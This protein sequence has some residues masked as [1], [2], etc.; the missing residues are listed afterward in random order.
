MSYFDK[1]KR[2][3]LLPAIAALN[4]LI[5]S[6]T[7]PYEAGS[8]NDPNCHPVI[9]ALVID[10]YNSSMDNEGKEELR[11]S[12]DFKTKIIQGSIDEDTPPRYLNHFMDWQ[13]GKGIW[14]FSS[15]LEWAISS[16]VQSGA[17]LP[18]E[19]VSAEFR[20]DYEKLLQQCNC[21]GKYPLGDKSWGEALGYL[22][23]QIYSTALG[24]VLHLAEDMT[25]PAHTRGDVHVL[26]ALGVEIGETEIKFSRIGDL[27]EYY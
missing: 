8:K 6:S 18:V 16:E 26:R 5:P 23:N 21:D 17:V 20:A 4:L 22:Q 9:T 15:A 1:L 12:Q 27:Y 25:V 10:A 14:G 24:H 7:L 13:T 2:K 3:W 11:I 19:K